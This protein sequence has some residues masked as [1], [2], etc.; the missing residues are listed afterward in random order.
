MTEPNTLNS[1]Y[2]IGYGNRAIGDF[3][4]LIKCYGID[5]VAD[6][7]SAPF[8]AF[9]EDFSKIK[10]ERR[11]KENGVGYLFIGRQLGGKPDDM[12][13]F[14]NEK[15]DYAKL[16]RAPFYRDGISRLAT[17]LDKKYRVALMCSELKPEQCHRSKL[18]S[19]TLVQNGI[20]VRHIDELGELKSQSEVMR[21]LTGG[22]QGLFGHTF[23]S[24]K[25]YRKNKRKL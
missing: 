18:I 20:D 22:Q 13:Y 4:A 2:T 9:N 16:S 12:K 8:S 23:G 17:A 15:I 5:Y 25:S 10:L 1:I 3:I 21:R 7:R 14:T 24:V 6:V 11:L 19:E